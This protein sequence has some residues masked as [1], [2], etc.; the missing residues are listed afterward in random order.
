M[1]QFSVTLG[2]E[3]DAPESIK[4]LEDVKRIFND[5]QSTVNRINDQD[6]IADIIEKAQE[7]SDDCILK[8]YDALKSFNYAVFRR[9]VPD[10]IVRDHEWFDPNFQC[11]R[12]VKAFTFADEENGR[13]VTD[14]Q[15]LH[16]V[17]TELSGTI[18]SLSRRITSAEL[19]LDTEIGSLDERMAEADRRLESLKKDAEDANARH[20]KA[21]NDYDDAK[22]KADSHDT[23][24][25]NPIKTI[26]LAIA[27][28]EIKV[29][30]SKIK[31]IKKEKDSI[32][33]MRDEQSKTR[34]TM[35][36]QRAGLAQASESLPN[37][38]D[39]VNQAR[40]SVKDTT[41][42][43]INTK[44][45]LVEVRMRH[46]A[47][48]SALVDTHFTASLP[49]SCFATI[50]RI[51]SLA[52]DELFFPLDTRWLYLYLDE[53]FR[54]MEKVPERMLVGEVDPDDYG[55]EEVEPLGKLLK[56]LQTTNE[57]RREIFQH[58]V[59]QYQS[60]NRRGF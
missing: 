11:K 58:I 53:L 29:A 20:Q 47:T 56:K 25:F 31:E 42:K 13:V 43:V 8:A 35:K 57:R 34:N 32:V 37:H 15:N 49:P 14:M 9:V 30:S 48:I 7:D 4:N 12:V 5:A 55:N 24:Q 41:D 18:E 21:Q 50:L 45:R 22:A 52:P 27:L 23:V 60:D 26:D 33:K 59:E 17:Y 44:Q 36:G 40:T 46:L 51:A 10:E 19:F 3:H 2:L 54:T 16:E 38:R 39:Q 1:P 6:P 28:N